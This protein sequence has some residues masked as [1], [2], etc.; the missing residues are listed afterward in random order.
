V[1]E[2][3]ITI[4]IEEGEYVEQLLLD[5]PITLKGLGDGVVLRSYGGHTL[6]ACSSERVHVIGIK[7][8]Q[9]GG[10]GSKRGR[11]SAR[12]VEVFTGQVVLERCSLQSEA[13]SGLIVADGGSATVK[14]CTMRSCGKCGLL[15]F[16]GGHLF[17][18]DR[19]AALPL[20]RATALAA[21]SMRESWCMGAPRCA[22]FVPTTC[23][24]TERWA[25]ACRAVLRFDSSVIASRGMCM[26]G[27]SWMGTAAGLQYE[28][29]NY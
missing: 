5:K 11:S 13:G 14:E 21:T 29:V 18:N 16:D 10:D 22:L 8:W 6:L 27:C 15:V 7:M 3:G 24:P 23:L 19:M 12:C 26:L 9:S 2:S 1:A 20:L 4:E 17:C 28:I 25:W